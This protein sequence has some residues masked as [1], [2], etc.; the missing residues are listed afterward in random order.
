MTG[1]K[2]FGRARSQANIV[3]SY[4]EELGVLYQF[5]LLNMGTGEHLQKSYLDLNP[6]GKVPGLQ[7]GDF[8]LW[9]SG[10]I[11][12][13]LAE[14]YWSLSLYERS[15]QNQWIYFANATLGPPQFGDVENQESARFLKPLNAQFN[16]QTFL[17]GEALAVADIAVGA[18]LVFATMLAGM[19]YGDYPAIT[20][21][22]KRLSE[23]PAYRK[24]TLKQL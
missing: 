17:T 10:A 19:N 20:N 18:T 6:F 16:T 24:V 23:R 13:C 12:L 2:L 22:V 14:K 11:L 5:V 7:D 15:L 9:E 1:L 4:L 8:Q 3:Q 21:Y